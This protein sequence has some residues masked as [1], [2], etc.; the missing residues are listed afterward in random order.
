MAFLL[1]NGLMATWP[2]RRLRLQRQDRY[3]RLP[4][5]LQGHPR[6]PD[7]HGGTRQDDARHPGQYLGA[8]AATSASAAASPR[9]GGNQL[10]RKQLLPPQARDAASQRQDPRRLRQLHGRV[11]PTVGPSLSGRA[12]RRA[13]RCPRNV[14]HRTA[15]HQRL[16]RMS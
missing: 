13:T 6:Q 14:W 5:L 10:S 8:L 3:R 11:D 2:F 4:K 16:R 9:K 1:K 15:T 7:R 12:L